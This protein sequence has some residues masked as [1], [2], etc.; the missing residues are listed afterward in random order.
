MRDLYAGSPGGLKAEAGGVVKG[1]RPGHRHA[2]VCREVMGPEAGAP[3]RG[4]TPTTVAQKA[5]RPDP[6]PTHRGP[7]LPHSLIE[8]GGSAERLPDV[9]RQ[10]PGVLRG[11][12]GQLLALGVVHVA[13]VVQRPGL[14]DLRVAPRLNL[15]RHGAREAHWP[16]TTVPAAPQRQGPEGGPSP[17]ADVGVGPAPQEGVGACL[18]VVAT[19]R[20][21]GR[22][23][24]PPR[25]QAWPLSDA[26]GKGGALGQ[27][28]TP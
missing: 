16:R 3:C 21:Q 8:L 22:R 26:G 4:R 9:G 23:M 1:S 17:S 18:R 14:P 25:E 28:Q 12:P 20:A 2:G 7:C 6:A 15:Y 13:N 24:P 5:L 10:V 19:L 27:A 11:V